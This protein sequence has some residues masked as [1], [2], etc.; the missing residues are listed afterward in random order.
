MRSALLLTA[1][2]LVVFAPVCFGQQPVAGRAAP[3]GDTPSTGKWH[4]S[5]SHG[6]VSA[7]G[8]EAV[9]IG[10]GVLESGGN[11]ADA[12]VATILGLAVTD[13]NMF[14]F[15]GEFSLLIYDAAHDR[16]EVVMGQGAAADWPLAS[17][18]LAR[19]HPRLRLARRGR[20]RRARCL[21]GR[22][23]ALW[24]L[25][26]CRRCPAEHRLA[27]AAPQS[28]ACRSGPHAES[29]GRGGKK[30][31][32]RSS[33]RGTCRPCPIISIAGRWPAEIG[34][35]CA[36]ND[37]LIRRE[38]PTWPPTKT[39][40]ESPVSVDYRG[41]RVFKCGPGTQGPYACSKPLQLLE[42]ASI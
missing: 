32:R 14:C 3:S 19:G 30:R 16:V 2:L 7:G 38:P 4:A 36:A 22:A 12:A 39:P 35:W 40:V 10:L 9:Q 18:L 41:H 21:R 6:A 33:G 17:C 5:G 27:R 42:P 23:P 26:V 25:E 1:C 28:L 29:L 15:G 37:G 31:R 20:A 13:S 11:A 24:Q 34:D 8:D